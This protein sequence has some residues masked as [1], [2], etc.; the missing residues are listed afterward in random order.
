MNAPEPRPLVAQDGYTPLVPS[1]SIKD[2]P[3]VLMGLRDVQA[4]I[5]K[6]GIAKLRKNKEQ[7]YQFRGIDDL[8]NE[9]CSML[10]DAYIVHFPFVVERIREQ[11]KT[12]SGKPMMGTCVTVDYHFYS[13]KDGSHVT[14][15]TIGEG[16]DLS[17]KSSNKSM[18]SAHKY[19]LIQTF[20]IPV[21]GSEDG[22]NDDHRLG[23]DKGAVA[24]RGGAKDEEKKTGA[25]PEIKGDD[26]LIPEPKN[27]DPA[28]TVAAMKKAIGN[29]KTEEHL[30][31]V[32]AKYTS[33]IKKWTTYAP[34][35]RKNWI[36][37]LTTEKDARKKALTDPAPATQTKEEK[38]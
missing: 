11:H 26:T 4:H 34:A 25:K 14:A 21:V 38:A 1:D 2:V 8:Y 29:A 36:E 6:Y 12:G 20:N 24:S 28:E 13:A 15:R 32:F 19:A 18:S 16:F 10:A 31:A 22:D 7:N 33:S 5:A 35:Q 17:D 27:V 3:H 9:L 30:R 23:A 37:Q